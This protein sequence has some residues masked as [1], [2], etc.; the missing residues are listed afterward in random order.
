[1]PARRDGDKRKPRLSQLTRALTR[2]DKTT[3]QRIARVLEI[4]LAQTSQQSHDAPKTT[5]VIGRFGKVGKPGKKRTK[6]P[7]PLPSNEVLDQ[8][9][10]HFDDVYRQLNEQLR[11]IGKVQQQVSGLVATVARLSEHLA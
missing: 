3:R 5:A 10:I 8:I 9:V 7:K 1:V 4:R 11:L 2:G 6:G